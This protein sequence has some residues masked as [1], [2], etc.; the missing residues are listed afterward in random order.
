MKVL[1]AVLDT[2]FWLGTHVVAVTIGYASTYVAGMLG[3]GYLVRGLFFRNL[4]KETGKTLA[5][6]IYGI[7][8]FALFFSFVGTVLGGIWAD[9]S[10]GRFRG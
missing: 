1:V 7:A 9:Q 10:W 2:N 6:M 3:I 4:D 8:C 5:K